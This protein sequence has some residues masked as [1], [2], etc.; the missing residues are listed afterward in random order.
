MTATNSPL[1]PSGDFLSRMAADHPSVLIYTDRRFV[2]TCWEGSDLGLDQETVRFSLSKFRGVRSVKDEFKGKVKP[3]GMMCCL[4]FDMSDKV[5]RDRLVDHVIFDHSLILDFD[6]EA[7]TTSP[8]MIEP[9]D[10]HADG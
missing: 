1:P 10:N 5:N 8:E 2:L 7:T 3:D 4:S 9:D 6:P